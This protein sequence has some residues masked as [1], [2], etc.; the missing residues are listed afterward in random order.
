MIS[1]DDL[2]IEEGIPIYLQILLHVKRG[3][4]LRE[5]SGMVMA[6]PSR[7][8]VSAYLGVNPNTV[9]KGIPDA[10]RG[11]ADSVPFGSQEPHG[12]SGGYGTATFAESC[13]SR[14]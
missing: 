8:V 10:G 13:W 2:R 14:S 5:E 6:L 9:Q 12:S 3:G 11:G 1:F 4:S 7:R